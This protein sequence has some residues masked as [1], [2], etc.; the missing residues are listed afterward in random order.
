MLLGLAL[1]AAVES[2]LGQGSFVFYNGGANGGA[3]GA[4]YG[5]D[6]ADPHRHQWGNTPEGRPAGTQVYAGAPL[7]GTAYSVEAWYSLTAATDVF[8]LQTEAS[9]ARR[10]LTTFFT[11]TGAGFFTGGDVSVSETTYNP[12]QPPGSAYGVWLQ[13]RAWDNAGGQL[14]TWDAAWKAALAGSGKAVGW[15]GVF[16]QSAR[17]LGVWP[18]LVNFESF[19]VA[20][21]P[22]PGTLSLAALG[23]AAW[24][25]SRRRS[26][27]GVGV[28]LL[29]RSRPRSPPSQ[30]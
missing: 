6:P 4:I 19:N 1:L 10:S 29:C 26:R 23:G 3:I 17:P 30:P 25:W 27:T 28:V 16:W 24:C 21:V 13:V 2:S 14:G 18:G 12:N 9:A 8:A 11:G 22:E 15:S 7:A 5:P 20:I